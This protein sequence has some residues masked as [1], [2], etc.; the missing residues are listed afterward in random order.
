MIDKFHQLS[1]QRR[2][3]LFL[4]AFRW[5]S[6]LPALWL[7][8]KPDPGTVTL[9][10]PALNIFLAAALNNLFIT[11]FHKHLNKLVVERPLLLVPDMLFSAGLLAASGGI[12]SP[13]YLYALSPLLAGAFFLQFRGAFA[14]AI[15]FTPLY[16]I[17]LL[18]SQNILNITFNGSALFTQLAGIWLV[19]ILFSYPA[20]L[21]NRLRH[22]RDDLTITRDNLTLQNAELGIA[23]R[24]LKVIHDLTVLIQAAPDIYSVQEQVLQAVNHELG[25]AGAALALV[26]PMTDHLGNWQI[27]PPKKTPEN[28]L[29]ALPLDR[30]N[31]RL[32][33]CLLDHEACWFDPGQPITNNLEINA[34]LAE[35]SW[36]A[37]PM[38]MQEHPVGVLMV[39]VEGGQEQMSEEQ[40]KVLNSVAN[41]AAVA[42]GTTLLCIDRARRLGIETER[43]R[44]ARDIHDTV[45]QSLFG[46]VF[47]ID[48]CI[49]MLPGNVDA[50]K[51]ELVELRTLADQTREEV[52]HSIFNLWPTQLTLERFKTDLSS[53]TSHCCRPQS[54]NVV[55]NTSGEF[56]QLSDGIRRSLY[57]V[58]Q[59]ALANSAR[60]SGAAVA[61]VD[62]TVDSNR[63]HLGIRD[64]GKGFDAMLAL[65][66][67][68]NR[69]SFGLHGIRE[70]VAAIGGDCKIESVNGQGTQILI[71]VPI[72]QKG[73]NNV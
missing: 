11:I 52:R 16:T 5:G 60:H 43:N 71:D 10:V 39:E 31:G 57:R 53:Y 12:Q 30:E 24:Q 6:L 19:T 20:V 41:Q 18:V 1:V 45:A 61:E 73:Q 48:A 49:K 2:V 37:L 59:E 50:V 13:Y 26:D 15:I 65:A 70:R 8:I 40:A 67:S 62:L 44:I 14:A 32:I 25:Y 21:L 3:F 64:A 22:T 35:G 54:F 27:L 29:A 58:A 63:V 69:E 47:S 4:V 55:F 34:W 68:H 51:G 42:L 36:L 46:I 9:I 56:E 72:I 66:R 38:I 33:N 28:G 7:L 17:A 23:H